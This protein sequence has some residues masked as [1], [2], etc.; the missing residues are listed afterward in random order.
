[1]H[2][3]ESQVHLSQLNILLT[4][5][6]HEVEHNL[7]VGSMQLDVLTKQNVIAQQNLNISRKAFQLG[8]LDLSDLLRIQTQTFNTERSLKNQQVQGLWNIARYN[9]AVGELP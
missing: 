8:E 5:S 7:E 2:Y 4:A 6:M 1:M 3:A 9:Q